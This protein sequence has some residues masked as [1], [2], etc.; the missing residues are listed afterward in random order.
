LDYG[1]S[2]SLRYHLRDH[3]GSVRA[4]VDAASGRK[5]EARD[6]YPYGLEMPERVYVSGAKT[7]QGYTGHDLDEVTGLNYAGGAITR[8]F[9]RLPDE[10]PGGFVGCRSAGH[11][12]TTTV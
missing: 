1:G 6:Y 3:L 12:P 10:D 7:K 2:G 8:Q 4:V 9:G 5:L 11:H